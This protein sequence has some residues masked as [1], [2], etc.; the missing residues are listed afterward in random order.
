[1]ILTTSNFL[2]A[3]RAS[4]SS[5]P[6]LPH[7]L[8]NSVSSIDPSPGDTGQIAFETSRPLHI[9]IFYTREPCK[10]SIFYIHTKV[11]I[12]HDEK[13]WYTGGE[14]K[15]CIIRNYY[16]WGEQKWTRVLLKLVF[17][18][19]TLVRSLASKPSFIFNCLLIHLFSRTFL[20]KDVIARA[21]KTIGKMRIFS[22]WTCFKAFQL[23]PEKIFC[24]HV[25]ARVANTETTYKFM[26]NTFY[27][28][29]CPL[30]RQRCSHWKGEIRR[31]YRGADVLNLL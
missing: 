26:Q 24:K 13:C 27:Y 11:K 5:T 4:A 29:E 18:I 15:V 21:E 3:S 22:L 10:L 20:R 2:N 9:Y 14:K 28:T 19:L 12:N 1:M 23:I 30:L 7:T 17:V 31:V 16:E 25:C 6:W 8:L